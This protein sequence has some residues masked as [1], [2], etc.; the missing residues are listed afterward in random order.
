MHAAATTPRLP[1][2]VLPVCNALPALDACLAALSRTLPAGAAVCIVDDASDDA[3]VAPLA[4]GW[5]ARAGRGA[6]YLRLDAR[7]GMLRA[8]QAALDGDA[9]SD[10]D[11][12]D[13]ARDDGRIAGDIVLLAADAVPTGDWLRKLAA[14][15]AR[16]PRAGSLVPWSNRDEIAAFPSLRAPNALPVA[17]D[18]DAIAQAAAALAG[19]DLAGDDLAGYELAP[20]LPPATGACLF[21]RRDAVAAVGGLDHATF[22]GEAGFDDLCRRADALGWRHVLCAGAYV[23]RQDAPLPRDPEARDDR[24]RLFA[25]WP[26][27]QARLA[28]AFLDDPLRGLRDR[29]QARLDAD[30]ARGPQRDLFQ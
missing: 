20:A 18:R 28:R 19:E 14:A 5:C 10:G 16:E 11:A 23:G 8:V 6:R 26:D 15:A 22:R 1:T 13:A 17:E 21:L 30:A 4:R 27:Q 29:L 24:A 25:R 7:R 2:V 3:Q 12:R 9:A